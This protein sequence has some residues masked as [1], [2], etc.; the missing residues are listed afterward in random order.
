V[1]WLEYP[2]VTVFYGIFDA[3]TIIYQ[4]VYVYYTGEITAHIIAS[5]H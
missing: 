1:P 2:D 4:N 3:R 5:V